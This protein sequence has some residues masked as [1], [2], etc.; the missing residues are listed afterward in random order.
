MASPQPRHYSHPSARGTY[1]LH[2]APLSFFTALARSLWLVHSFLPCARALVLSQFTVRRKRFRKAPWL[3]IRAS[4]HF[5]FHRARAPS[6]KC[7]VDSRP[8]MPCIEP[9]SRGIPRGCD[10][11]LLVSL[12]AAGT[13]ARHHVKVVCFRRAPH[14]CGAVPGVS[15]GH[16]RI[17]STCPPVTKRKRSRRRCAPWARWFRAIGIR[18][19]HADT[20]PLHPLHMPAVGAAEYTPN[21]SLSQV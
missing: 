7:P 12:H 6:P 14:G 4:L 18:D 10:R 13:H 21:T 9:G 5:V 17:I 1:H 2:L 11:R 16:T 19:T 8:P 20:V 15:G 3:Q